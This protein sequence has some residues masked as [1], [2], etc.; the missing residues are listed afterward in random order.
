MS[1]RSCRV[2][3]VT[4]NDDSYEIKGAEVGIYRKSISYGFSPF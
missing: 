1:S 3:E 4:S 2:T